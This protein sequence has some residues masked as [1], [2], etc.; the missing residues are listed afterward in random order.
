MSETSY[1]IGIW[2]EIYTFPSSTLITSPSTLIYSH[3]VF[4]PWHTYVCYHDFVLNS[5]ALGYLWRI[6]GLLISVNMWSQDCPL[7]AFS[8]HLP[9][10]YS[11]LLQKREGNG[12]AFAEFLSVFKYKML[13]GFLHAG[14]EHVKLVLVGVWTYRT[15]FKGYRKNPINQNM[16]GRI[17]EG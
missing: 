1:F 14:F 13:S 16:S 9:N 17:L 10:P 3:S 15:D 7:T 4:F 5:K 6:A 11:L 12:R 8:V 2:A